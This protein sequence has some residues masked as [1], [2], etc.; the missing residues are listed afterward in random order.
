MPVHYILIQPPNDGTT[1]T[2]KTD[3]DGRRLDMAKKG[4]VYSVQHIYG[5][6]IR[7]DSIEHSKSSIHIKTRKSQHKGKNEEKN[8]SQQKHSMRNKGT[9]ENILTKN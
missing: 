3:Y 8:N 4:T 7:K 6:G 2:T 9:R 5:N 1:T